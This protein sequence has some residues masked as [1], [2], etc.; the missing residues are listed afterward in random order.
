MFPY[1]LTQMNPNKLLIENY[2]Y[3]RMLAKALMELFP[4]S[5]RN[6]IEKWLHRL[7]EMNHTPEQLLYRSHYMWFL[8]LVM[9]RGKLTT[10][11]NQS[12]PIGQ[13][14]PLHEVLPVEVYED[15]INSATAQQ[16]NQSWIDTLAAEGKAQEDESKKGL[17]PCNFFENQPVPA[18][19]SFC[20]AA[21]FSD[22]STT[23]E[24]V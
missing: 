24:A 6:K 23:P 13:L 10:P 5:D 1:D 20:Y 7:E 9:Q 8:L 11:F 21:V 16:Q 14:K 12:P 2:D 17:F 18:E 19:G 22:Y 15:I 4:L 3:N